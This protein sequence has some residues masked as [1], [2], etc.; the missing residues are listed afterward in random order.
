MTVA[1]AP[2]TD[3]HAAVHAL[4]RYV[5]DVAA[6]LGV[7][8]ESC[9]VD[10]DSPV[11]AYLALDTRLPTHP[12]RDLALLWHEEHGWSAAIETHSGED[13][14]VVDHLGGPD[15]L[16]PPHRVARFVQDLRTAGPRR[17]EPP[18]LRTRGTHADLA[19]LLHRY[20]EVA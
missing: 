11:S 15:V 13:L 5:G 12:H 7:G 10:Q 6:A 8:L 14:L 1:L 18:R 19:R 17:T 20:A 3:Q 16:P 9:T 2:P 4:H